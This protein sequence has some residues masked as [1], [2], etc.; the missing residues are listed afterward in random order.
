MRPVGILG[1]TFDPIHPGHL[2][3]ALA[4]V[5]IRKLEKIIFIPCNISPHKQKIIHSDPKHRLNMVN[6]AIKGI[7]YFESSDID[8]KR[9]GISYMV[10]TLSE[11]KKILNRLELI[12]G[13]DNIEKFYTWKE[14][15]KLLKFAKLI[16]MRRE[17]EKEILYR[18]KYYKSAIFV[19]TPAI[20]I[21]ATE[22]RKRVKNNLPIDFLVTKEVKNYISK[23]NL[24]KD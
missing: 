24:Y 10:D 19:K 7:P 17:I 23:N 8:I 14:P 15:D 5:E 6:L 3:T 1:G 2:I 20:D 4:L 16:V 11:L 18:D 21:K 13:Y 22:I 12:I 9:G